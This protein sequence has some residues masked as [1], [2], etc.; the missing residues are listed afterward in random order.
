MPGSDGAALAANDIGALHAQPWKF[1]L[2]QPGEDGLAKGWQKPGFDDAAWDTMAVPGCWDETET[3]KCKPG[4]AWYRRRFVAKA[5]R[6]DWE[7][8]SHRFLLYGKGVA[9]KGT[10]WLNG[11][12]VGEVAGWDTRYEFDVSALLRYGQTNDLVFRVD[13]AGYQNGLRFYCHIL[14]NDRINHAKRFG[15]QQY[16]MMLWPYLMHGTSGCWVWSWHND[17]LRPHFPRLV[18]KLEAASEVVLPDL[19]HRRGEVAYLYGFLNGRG[20]PCSIIGNHTDYL[21]WYNAIEFSGVR[22]DVFGERHFVKEIDPKRYRLLV[23]PYTK[24]VADDTYAAFKRYVLDGGTAVVTEGALE[25]TFTRYA[26]TDIRTFAGIDAANGREVVETVRGKGRVVFVAGRPD[27]ERLMTILKPYLPKPEIAVATSETREPP[28]VERVLAGDATRKILYLANWGGLDK[29]VT[30]TLPDAVRGWKLTPIESCTQGGPSL[31]DGEM[32]VRI[33]SQD[34]AVFLLEA[35]GSSAPALDWQVPA[36]QK[37]ALDHVVKLNEPP[38]GNGPRALFPCF[39]QPH[40]VTPVGKELYPYVLD[41]LASFGVSA[42]EQ[43]IETW[44]PELLKRSAVVVLPE[45]NT[46]GFFRNAKKMKALGRMLDDYV[47]DGGALFVLAHTAYQVNNYAYTLTSWAGLAPSLGASLADGARDARHAGLGD[48]YQ[49]LTENL[50]P[51]PLTEGVRKVQLYNLRTLRASKQKTAPKAVPV[52]KIPV[53]AESGADAAAMVAVEHG[54]G[55]MFLSADAMAFQPFRIELAD[56]AA[57]LENIVGWLLNRPV[58]P[59]MR[60]AF[61]ANLAISF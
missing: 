13:G 56:N 8:G 25:R 51:G 26:E 14:P 18:R 57:L 55:R 41:R 33:P 35:P 27:M 10:I 54:K 2:E 59:E 17:F 32:T 53:G 42:E 37:A 23:V 34:V 50:V 12:K 38:M 20:L 6:Q 45:T 58:T 60:D 9:Q 49:I 46:Q 36:A 21:N 43:D 52:V 16:R 15:A 29:D 61:R 40:G 5:N 47:R 7:D 39:K 28:L 1:H 30:V 22:P 44:T 48:P 24:F 31:R 11:E 19:R 3:Y 4:V